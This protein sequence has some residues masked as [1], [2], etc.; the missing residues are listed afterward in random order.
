MKKLGI[1]GVLVTL[2]LSACGTAP[3]SVKPTE[4]ALGANLRDEVVGVSLK[5][6]AGWTV[7][8]D[9]AL[10]DTHGFFL[11]APT[12]ELGAAQTGHEQDAV[13]HIALAYK[14]KPS[15]LE[16][17]V[18]KTIEQH[19]EFDLTRTEVTLADGLKGVA[20]GGLPGTQPYTVVYTAAGKQVYEIGL[21]S[22][23]PG[24]D[25]RAHTLLRNLSFETPTKSVASLKLA[26]PQEA[27]Y[28]ALPTE[29]AL[30]SVKAAA[31]RKELAMEAVKAGTLEVEHGM[32]EPPEGTL[33]AASC[34]F[35]AP[36][37]LYWQLQWDKTNTFYRNKSAGHSAMSGNG[38]SWWGTGYHTRRCDPYYANQHYANDWPAQRG[39]NAYSAFS[40]TVEWAGWGTGG[41]RTLGLYV[42][43]RNGNYRSLTAHLT[44]LKR[45]IAKGKQING[46]WDVIGFAG[47]TGG[48]WAPHLHARVSYGEKLSNGQPYGGQSVKPRALRCFACTN[49]DKNASGNGGWFTNFYHG[50]YMKY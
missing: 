5:V 7:L 39:A 42:V 41:F 26:S 43:V 3:D 35:T 8:R 47:S 23:E 36:A 13:A 18:Q 37:G 11:H 4:P 38:G 50:R 49:P 19:R 48:N 24:L 10:F 29:V 14:A 31:E 25:A 27:L 2:L 15:Q 45:G 22:D 12:S 32:M 17:L 46:Y 1:V 40:G 28:R 21:W 6:P 20:I 30:G 34:G 44:S 16:A 9:E 33:S